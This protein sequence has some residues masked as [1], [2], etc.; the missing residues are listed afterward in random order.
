[1]ARFAPTGRKRASTR[2]APPA[3]C[4]RWPLAGVAALAFVDV[5]SASQAEGDMSSWDGEPTTD[6]NWLEKLDG[7][8]DDLFN[9]C[10]YTTR[11]T[12]GDFFSFDFEKF[13]KLSAVDN[14][15]RVNPNAQGLSCNEAQIADQIAHVTGLTTANSAICVRNTKQSKGIEQPFEQPKATLL[16]PVNPCP[17]CGEGG[18]KMTEHYCATLCTKWFVRGGQHE[19]LQ[20]YEV[21]AALRNGD[22][23]WCTPAVGAG[24]HAEDDSWPYSSKH[25]VD[26]SG[27]TPIPCEGES[28]TIC[29][30]TK[31]DGNPLETVIKIACHSSLPFFLYAFIP[32]ICRVVFDGT[33]GLIGLWRRKRSSRSGGLDAR[34]LD[35]FTMTTLC[36]G[37]YNSWAEAVQAN[38]KGPVYSYSLAAFRLLGHLSQPVVCIFLLIKYASRIDMIDQTQII[39]GSLVAV[40]EGFYFIMTCCLVYLK[41][42]FLLVNIT[43]SAYG[44]RD[45]DVIKQGATFWFMYL[46]APEKFVA[47]VLFQPHGLT[48]GTASVMN[49]VNGSR[50]SASAAPAPVSACNGVAFFTSIFGGLLLDSCAVAA[51]VSGYLSGELPWSIAFGYIMTGLGGLWM[52]CV[53]LYELL[54]ELC[55]KFCKRKKQPLLPGDPIQGGY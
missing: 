12:F 7:E 10:G 44:S 38:D 3:A 53:L 31:P 42:S 43:S 5:N 21:V 2:G 47:F 52:L 8:P 26:A 15:Y 23:C 20:R 1:M 33:P 35:G 40:R 30:G 18:A 9:S 50:G 29:G 39:L 37:N 24:K 36:S 22:Q 34:N 19:P 14:Y 16:N 51:I 32:F 27:V 41:P 4:L 6:P 13:Y 25:H 17:I 55:K 48:R 28:G 49:D 46:F 11:F 54:C 45:G